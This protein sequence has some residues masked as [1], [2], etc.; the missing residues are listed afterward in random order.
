[1]PCEEPGLR[2]GVDDDAS[3]P[4]AATNDAREFELL[5]Y[6]G[7]GSAGHAHKRAL[8]PIAMSV[9][10]SAMGQSFGSEGLGAVLQTR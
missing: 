2:I 10:G 7:L 9:G 5:H 6:N 8:R 3:T 1:M 4:I